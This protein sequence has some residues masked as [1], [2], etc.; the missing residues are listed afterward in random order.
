ML[1]TM[2]RTFE[3]TV[4]V[5]I[6]ANLMF[7]KQE[8]L[9][10]AVDAGADFIVAETYDTFGEALLAAKACKEFAKGCCFPDLV[11]YSTC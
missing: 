4:H 3:N 7:V 5:F 1:G 8:Q 9:E 2:L 11:S 6:R 10:W